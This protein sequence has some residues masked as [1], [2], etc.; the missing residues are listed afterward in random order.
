MSDKLFGDI[1]H[2]IVIT[3]SDFLERVH[4]VFF[5]EKCYGIVIKYLG[6]NIGGS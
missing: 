5:G 3:F 2:R 1:L 4:N 6:K